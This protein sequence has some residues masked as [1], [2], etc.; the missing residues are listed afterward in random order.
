MLLKKMIFLDIVFQKLEQFELIRFL[1]CFIFSKRINDIQNGHVN[2]MITKSRVIMNG[3]VE[4]WIVFLYFHVIVSLFFSWSLFS[5]FASLCSLG[6]S[7]SVSLIF[8]IWRQ[9][10]FLYMVFIL[11]YVVGI[12]DKH[13]KLIYK[14]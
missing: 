14:R 5:W 4:Q 7:S 12:Q 3:I 6:V 13:V 1:V 10:L 2:I 11:F 8:L 9:E